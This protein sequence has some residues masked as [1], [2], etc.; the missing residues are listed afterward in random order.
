M[1]EEFVFD[2]IVGLNIKVYKYGTGAPSILLT[3]GI[4]GDEV[5]SVL[6]L[7][8]LIRYLDIHGVKRGTVI[9]V[10]IVNPLGLRLKRRENPLDYMDINRVFPGNEHGSISERIAYKIWNIALTTDYV[11]DLH[12]GG[13]NSIPYVLALH[14]NYKYVREF[15]SKIPIE[16]VVES[17][18]LR[19]QLFIEATLN[20]IPSALIEVPGGLGI[21]IDEYVHVLFE[22]L[23]SLLIRLEILDGKAKEIEQTYYNGYGQVIAFK[24]GVFRPYVIPGFRIVEETVIGSINDEHIKSGYKGLLLSISVPQFIT[25]GSVIARIALK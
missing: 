17:C 10:P 2:E 6:A 9:L 3:A 16:R 23:K 22:A 8:E 13:L 11:L 15:T 21:F 1:V 20:K 4:H 25:Q 5:T 24:D 12:C 7:L 18:G 14:K 19:G